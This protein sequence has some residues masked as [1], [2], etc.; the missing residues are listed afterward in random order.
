MRGHRRAALIA[1]GVLV[2]LAISG[3]LARWLS[4]EN[5]ERSDVL[6]ML[7]AEARGDAAGM[8]AQLHDCAGRCRVLVRADARALK[9]PGKVLILAYQSATSYALTSRTGDTRVAWK[10]GTHLPVVQCVAVSRRGNA[11][12][13]LTVRLLAVGLKI[14]PTHDCPG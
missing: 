10:V 5:V 8:L 14:P 9:R 2:F 6:A 11:L 4:V 3:A 1:V 13:G 7:T 12:S